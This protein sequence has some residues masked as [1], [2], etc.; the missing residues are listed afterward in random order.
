MLVFLEVKK[1]LIYGQ[2][3]YTPVFYTESNLRTMQDNFA[4]GGNSQRF[5]ASSAASGYPDNH[6][7]FYTHT[8]SA[9]SCCHWSGKEFQFQCYEL[10]LIPP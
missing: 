6:A 10:L 9:F 4:F 2:N 7:G 8:S 3:V 1:Q 5:G